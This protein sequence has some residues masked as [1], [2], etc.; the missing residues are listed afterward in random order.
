MVCLQGFDMSKTTEDAVSKEEHLP[1]DPRTPKH[2][3]CLGG[4][5]SSRTCS[6]LPGSGEESPTPQGAR[7]SDAAPVQMWQGGLEVDPQ[8]VVATAISC[9]ML[10]AVAKIL[11]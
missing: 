4:E 9:L 7:S 6:G 3:S 8:M 10:V 5:E 2:H 1:S 11:H